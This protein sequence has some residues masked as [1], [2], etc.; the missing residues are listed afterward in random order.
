VLQKFIAIVDLLLCEPAFLQDEQVDHPRASLL[1]MAKKRAGQAWPALGEPLLRAG[2][3]KQ[4]PLAS[5]I[6]LR[7]F[8]ERARRWRLPFMAGKPGEG[9]SGMRRRARRRPSGTRKNTH[10]QYV[11][12][13][14][15]TRRWSGMVRL[16]RSSLRSPQ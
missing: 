10:P 15:S 3:A 11:L 1:R 7:A 16:R 13:A 5:V 12:R 4:G 6:A 9:K 14:S 2:T 8:C